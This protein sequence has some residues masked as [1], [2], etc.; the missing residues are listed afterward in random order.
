[1]ETI[2]SKELITSKQICRLFAVTSFVCLTALSA[3]VRLPLPFTPVPLTL[4]TFFVL[5]SGALLGKKLGLTVQ[6]VYI[7]LGLIGYQVFTGL[8]SGMLYLIGPTGGYLVGF[9]LAT[10]FTGSLFSQERTKS[11]SVLT[12]L[13]IADLMILLSGTIWLKFSLAC[14]W[15]QAF[16]LGFFPFVLGEIFKIILASA[17]IN[18]MQ[19]RIKAVLR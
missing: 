7:L 18:R 15:R 3:F 4:Q 16:L 12:K 17:V 11:F 6:L 5:L 9:L 2:I 8:G 14:S 19:A 13:I 1:M 10:M